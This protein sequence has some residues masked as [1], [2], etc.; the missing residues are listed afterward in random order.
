[1]S[2]ASAIAAR[3]ALENP[4]APDALIAFLTITHPGLAEP[5]RVV[6][7]VMDYVYG[8]ET[9]TGIP[10]GF[11]LLSDD[12]GNPVT[13]LRLANADRRLSE[14]VRKF[15]GRP[16]V[17]LA[18]CSSAD[19]DLSA[20]PRVPLGTPA[21]LYGFSHFSLAEVQVS[22]AEITGQVILQD[23]SV[24]P[25]RAERATQDRLPGLFR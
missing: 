5:I 6:S 19:F 24:E 21:V 15:T 13:Q 22:G 8:G 10:F 3:A 16:Q 20:D 7:D 23:F 2:R 12:D 14:A 25:T 4:E 9:H 11:R 1:V 17:A 18:L